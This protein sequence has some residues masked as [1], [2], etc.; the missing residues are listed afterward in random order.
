MKIID[1]RIYTYNILL[2]FL[3]DD[4]LI[5]KYLKSIVELLPSQIYSLEDLFSDKNLP[6]CSEVIHSLKGSLS[7]LEG[8]DL[9]GKILEIEREL[10]VGK[11]S[12]EDLENLFEDLKKLSN[13]FLS[14][15]REIILML[16]EKG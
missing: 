7:Y 12:D 1:S 5:S 6:A 4:A 15:F 10:E 3:E 13:V 14:D 11:A 2:K 8:S 9:E 16:K